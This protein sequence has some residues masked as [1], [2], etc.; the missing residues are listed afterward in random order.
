MLLLSLAVGLN[1]FGTITLAKTY[2]IRDALVL[3]ELEK[4]GIKVW[5]IS[6]EASMRS[7]IDYESI[8]LFENYRDSFRITG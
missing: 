5:M 1:I 3:E 7:I 2:N 6:S 8:D 4:N